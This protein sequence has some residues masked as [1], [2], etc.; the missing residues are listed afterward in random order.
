MISDKW[1]ILG[2]YLELLD[3]RIKVYPRQILYRQQIIEV[4]RSGQKLSL[5]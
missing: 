5:L 1:A 3:V 2:F 4:Y